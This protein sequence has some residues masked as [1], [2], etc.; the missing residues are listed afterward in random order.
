MEI[1]KNYEVEHCRKGNFTGRCIAVNGEFATIELTAGKAS[2]ICANNEA[3]PGE[4]VEVRLS[5]CKYKEQPHD[6]I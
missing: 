1:G 4:S 3:F 6:R 2:A 5:F